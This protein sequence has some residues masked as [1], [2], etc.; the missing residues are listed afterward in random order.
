MN[1]C[2]VFLSLRPMKRYVFSTIHA[3]IVDVPSMG[4]PAGLLVFLTLSATAC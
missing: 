4:L 1:T 3:I 2:P